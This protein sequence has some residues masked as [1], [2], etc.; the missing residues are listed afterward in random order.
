MFSKNISV[1]LGALIF[2]VFFAYYHYTSN[3]LPLGAGPDNA[4]HN[5]VTRFIATHG[6]LPT[7]PRD[8]DALLFTPY[9]GTRALR[10]PLTY[11]VSAAV[12]K[13]PVF[14]KLHPAVAY[15][16]GS[17]LLT[18]L[19]IWIVFHTLLVYFR[20]YGL[21]FMGAA[22]LGLLPQYVFI[23]SYNNDDSGAIFSASL[24]FLSLVR[25]LCRGV[26]LK[27]CVLF[28]IAA[29]LVIL[30]KMTAWLLLPT[31]AIFLLIFVRCSAKRLLGYSAV[32]VVAAALSGGWWLVFN[33]HHYGSDDPFQQKITQEAA[34]R[35]TRFAA[36]HV[37][38]YKA[39]DVG[40]RELVF[41]N[42]DN[43]V[44]KTYKSVIGNLDWLRLRFGDF[45]YQFYLSLFFIGVGYI[46][47]R[48]V[49]FIYTTVFNGFVWNTVTQR[50]VFEL[51]MLVSVLFQFSIYVWANI[52]NDIQTQGK[53]L[54]PVVSAVLILGLSG[55]R[56]LGAGVTTLQERFDAG[57]MSIGPM[58][59][60]GA[61]VFAVLVVALCLHI[62]SWLHY[63]IPFYDTPEYR[64]ELRPF[65]AMRL[66]E[67]D[68]AEANDIS[69]FNLTNGA[70]TL[71]TLAGDPWV[72]LRGEVCKYLVGDVLVRVRIESDADE[73]FKIYWDEGRG[74]N[75][76]QQEKMI[77]KQ[78]RAE[79]YFGVRADNCKALRLDPRNSAGTTEILE[80][81]FARF[82]VHRAD[83]WRKH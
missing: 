76:A 53:Y 81:A 27:N 39:K 3:H 34:Q 67:A 35:H 45:Q 72:I 1:L 62:Y 8:E 15:R 6:R 55:L 22:L 11:I 65:K 69:E 61:G 30:S 43:F 73:S 28:G 33:I 60:K 5:D 64:L 71:H 56:L 4:A 19:T 7:I 51:L 40:F 59:V 9:G 25:F 12:S 68:I 63:V 50:T 54:L 75:E 66:T 79:V 13:I 29:G 24:M 26:T 2:A 18:S 20:S 21:A 49:W 70:L 44:E 80:I 42:Y 47:L 32:V 46:L 57:E 17:V 48:L 52:N 10:P 77:Y 38:G 37:F 78:G 14:A 58:A 74:F 36:G 31:V 82:A 83:D 23:A 16:K 41:D